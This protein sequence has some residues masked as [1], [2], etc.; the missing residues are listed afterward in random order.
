M[1]NVKTDE[2]KFIAEKRCL[3]GYGSRSRKQ[4]EALFCNKHSS[5]YLVT[6]LKKEYSKKNKVSKIL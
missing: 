6:L 1:L 3:F 4:F 2:L 5:V